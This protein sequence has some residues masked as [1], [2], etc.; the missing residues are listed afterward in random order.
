MLRKTP[1]KQTNRLAAAEGAVGGSIEDSTQKAGHPIYEI[2]HA[3]D[4][5]R[6]A[7]QVARK[8]PF[9]FTL[10]GRAENYLFER[11]DLKK[12]RSSASKRIKR[13][14]RM[15]STRPGSQTKMTSPP[16]SA[17][18]TNRVNVLAGLKGATLDL[19]G[20][21]AIGV[22]R[23]SVGSALSRAAYG[24]FLRG[25]EEMREHGTFKFADEAVSFHDLG[26]M[27]PDRKTRQ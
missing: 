16:W 2:A 12:T 13:R 7:A 22:K 18:S 6:A 10:T 1:P 11:P 3:S 21:S 14:A 17:R 24:A 9:T 19:A 23:I 4:R 26:A 5:I 25:A 15:F 20:L 27:F 8:F